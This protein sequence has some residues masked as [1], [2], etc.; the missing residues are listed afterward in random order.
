MLPDSSPDAS[1]NW[2]TILYLRSAIAA[3]SDA[4]PPEPAPAGLVCSARADATW[5]RYEID[6]LLR[7]TR[8]VAL[9]QDLP[10]LL[11]YLASE[12]CTLTQ[13]DACSIMLSEPRGGFALAAARGL[14]PN[15][16][17]FLQGD[18]FRFGPSGADYVVERL[19]PLV[20]NDIRTDTF[21]HR[22][23]SRELLESATREG[24]AALLSVPMVSSARGIGALAVYRLEATRPWSDADIE[25]MSVLGQHAAGVIEQARFVAAERGRAEAL[26]GLVAVLRD[27][28]HEYANRLHALS[29]LLALGATQDAREFLSQLVSLHQESHASV[30]ERINDPIVAGLLVAQMGIGRQRGVDVRLHRASQVDVL[31]PALGRLELVTILANLTQNAIE[32]TVDQ[33]ARRRRVTVRVSQGDRALRITVRDWGEGADGPAVAAM[34]DR[35]VS[36]KEDHAGIGL[37]LVAEAVA[38]LDGDIRVEPHAVGTSFHVVLPLR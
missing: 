37:A 2:S 1:M 11:D 32:A 18:F 10:A 7:V 14:S 23:E 33:P 38:S 26:A 19:E 15:Y 13:A 8:A 36:G 27:Q 3:E 4:P 12:A 24:Y 16:T 22:P 17:K 5:T 29:G 20:V 25:F 9:H 35:G 31:S 28:T 30:V 6:A 34:F 21:Y